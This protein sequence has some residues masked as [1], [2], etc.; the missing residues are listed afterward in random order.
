MS[1]DS[2][3]HQVVNAI[4]QSR[5][6]TLNEQLT[7]S[8]GGEQAGELSL[9][10]GTAKSGFHKGIAGLHADDPIV[11]PSYRAPAYRAPETR[12]ARRAMDR[13]DFQ[14]LELRVQHIADRIREM[15]EEFREYLRQQQGQG[16]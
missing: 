6:Q 14:T 16:G 15:W 3:R 5:K 4:I 11:V 10:G 8:S 7:T 1:V 13:K 12:V 2:L 9:L